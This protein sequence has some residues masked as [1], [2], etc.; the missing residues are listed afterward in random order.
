MRRVAIIAAM[1]GALSAPASGHQMN[2]HPMDRKGDTTSFAGVIEFQMR[3][4]FPDTTQF[5]IEVVDFE[6]QEPIPDDLW[7]SDIGPGDVVELVPGG[8]VLFRV[9]LREQGRVL[10]CSVR[11][12]LDVQTRIC[13]PARKPW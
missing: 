5:A 12:G 8:E 10:V 13:A 4:M 2:Y 9:Q 11:L 6:T 7:R 3:N 1:V